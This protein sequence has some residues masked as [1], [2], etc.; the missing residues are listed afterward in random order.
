MAKRELCRAEIQEMI[1]YTIEAGSI[2]RVKKKDELPI[3]LVVTKVSRG[4][5]QGVKLQTKQEKLV[6]DSNFL[7]TI[8]WCEQRADKGNKKVRLRGC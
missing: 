8:C 2:L 4:W 1:G 3:H 7:S 6:C 5:I